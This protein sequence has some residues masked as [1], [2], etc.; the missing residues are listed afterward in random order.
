[1]FATWGPKSYKTST[2]K[3]E[4]ES[5]Q[6]RRMED[7]R[8]MERRFISFDK[9]EY[10]MFLICLVVSIDNMN[11]QPRKQENKMPSDSKTNTKPTRQPTTKLPKRQKYVGKLSL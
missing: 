11:V 7:E 9:V 4:V 10:I 3:V 2:K 5:T 6:K 1:M 8:C